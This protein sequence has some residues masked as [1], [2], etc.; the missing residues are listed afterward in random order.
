M[1]TSLYF[2]LRFRRLEVA[3]TSLIRREAI[4]TAVKGGARPAADTAGFRVS[5]PENIL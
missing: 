4:R 5:G 1:A 2:Y 3:L